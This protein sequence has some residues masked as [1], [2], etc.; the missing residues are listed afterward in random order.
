MS[1]LA[2]QLAVAPFFQNCGDLI[3]EIIA[4]TCR[5]PRFRVVNNNQALKTENILL[6]I[7]DFLRQ[8]KSTPHMCM[9]HCAP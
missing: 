1:S 6:F 5:F 8:Q 7:F 9:C 4:E 2:T 3:Y